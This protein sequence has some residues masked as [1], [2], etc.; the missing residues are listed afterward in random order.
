MLQTIRE[1]SQGMIAKV[2]VGLIAITF[3]LWGVESLV[4]LANQEPA[5]AEVNGEEITRPA[6]LQGMEQQRRQLL[7]QMGE[8]ADPAA[9][10]D[11]LLRQMVL[12]GLIQRTVLLQ[13]AEEM[14]MSMPEQVVDQVIVGTPQFQVDGKFDRNQFQAVLRSAGFTPL[15]YRDL[16]RKEKLIEQQQAGFMLS[17]FT[18]GAEIE[19]LVALD[20]Q[21]RDLAYVTLQLDP[22]SIEVDEA[23]L[24]AAYQ[25]RMDAFMTPEQVAVDYVLLS[26]ADFADPDSVTEADLRAAYDQMLAGYQAQEERSAR[27]ILIDI[28]DDRDADAALAKAQELR[29]AIAGGADFA[30]LAREE[31]ADLGSAEQGGDLGYNGTG[32]F[33]EPFED[34]L[35]A[36][37]PG[38]VS[39]PV[40]TEFGYHL[41]KLDDVRETEVPSLAEVEMELRDQ[42]AQDQAEMDYVAALE[43]LA[44]LTFS[45]SDLQAAAEELS[46]EIRSTDL[47]SREGGSD[48]VSSSQRVV[49]AAFG[50]QVLNDQL[51]SDPIELSNGETVV[52]HLKDHQEPRQRTLA[53]VRDQLVAQL[54]QQQ[55]VDRLAAQAQ[56]WVDR[57]EQ[58]EALDQI[59]PDKRW[60]QVEAADR[61]A[62]NL[63]LP[64]LGKAF[65]LPAPEG[66]ARVYATAELAGGAYAIVA[67]EG[68]T[69]GSTDLSDQERQALGSMIANQRGQQ[70]YQQHASTLLEKAEVERN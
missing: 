15:M 56:E 64:V 30:E 67:L 27:H 41:I 57:L 43:R 10:D 19:Q 50:D 17:E 29:E 32:V 22:A 40:R 49:E 66:D 5:P 36:L 60:T 20:R 12:D 28:N 33:V 14:G 68:V 44:D 65:A 42:V 45:S 8:N 52:V 35:F 16:V 37:S 59:D 47:F 69:P 63:P 6:L 34:A 39:E 38:E 23:D 31:S 24:E 58:G 25:S 1:N 13:S 51:N 7:A 21:T 2:I 55:A 9:I 70:L 18:T 11:K 4:S 3:A 61:G 26:Q 53:E 46:L 62:E 54:Q 48:P